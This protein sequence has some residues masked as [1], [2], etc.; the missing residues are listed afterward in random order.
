MRQARFLHTGSNVPERVV[1]NVEGEVRTRGDVPIQECGSFRMC[2]RGF[3][4]VGIQ[5]RGSAR[6]SKR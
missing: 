1:T 4:P 6:R 2:D 5:G 3:R